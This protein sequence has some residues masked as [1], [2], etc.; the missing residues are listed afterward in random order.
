MKLA[1]IKNIDF[2]RW[3]S[4]WLIDFKPL[5]NTIDLTENLIK[6]GY[7]QLAFFFLGNLQRPFKFQHFPSPL[8]FSQT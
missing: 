6:P 5:L 4:N 2:W 8:D 7:F 3:E 1:N